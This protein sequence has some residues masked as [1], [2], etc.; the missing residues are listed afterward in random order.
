MQ[1]SRAYLWSLAVA[2]GG[3]LAL[4]SSVHVDALVPDTWTLKKV[5]GGKRLCCAVRAVGVEGKACLLHA[6]SATFSYPFY[7]VIPLPLS[8]RRYMSTLWRV[9]WRSHAPEYEPI[10]CSNCSFARICANWFLCLRWLLDRIPKRSTLQ[11]A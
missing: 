11:L 6:A 3:D 10:G 2:P 1:T 5:P 4:P 7:A 9:G 8:C